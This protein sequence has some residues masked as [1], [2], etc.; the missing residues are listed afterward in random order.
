M[1][2]LSSPWLAGAAFLLLSTAALTP[3]WVVAWSDP[4]LRVYATQAARPFVAPM[5]L[6]WWWAPW[7]TGALLAVA[8]VWLFLRLA[9]REWRYS[10]RTWRRT[11]EGCLALT[12]LAVLSALLWPR[13]LPWFWGGRSYALGNGTALWHETALPGW[14]WWLGLVGAAALAAARWSARADSGSPGGAPE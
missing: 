6:V 4:Q 1:A 8:V 10:T 2:R 3:W 13:E 11:L 7:V 5:D 14:G 12:V 9:G